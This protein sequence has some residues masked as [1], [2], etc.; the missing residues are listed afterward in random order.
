MPNPNPDTSGLVPW[1]PGQSGNPKGSRPGRR[2]NDIL[3]GALDS[4]SLC[5]QE[6]PGGR[7]VAESLIES[8][9]AHAIKSGNPSLIKEIFDRIDGRVP[10]ATPAQADD[11]PASPRIT[12]PD[13]DPRFVDEGGCPAEEADPVGPDA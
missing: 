12:I 3:R 10:K 11:V 13:H 7:T 6:V 2:L 5:D 8:A 4:T 9:I 1:K